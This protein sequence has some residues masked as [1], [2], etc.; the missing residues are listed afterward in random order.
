MSMGFKKDSPP[1]RAQRKCFVF[2][3]MPKNK[4]IVPKNINRHHRIM[5]LVLRDPR[6]AP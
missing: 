5:H 3:E 2:R 6:I 4:T 1:Q